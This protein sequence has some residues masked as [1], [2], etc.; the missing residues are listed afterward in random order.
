M[1][2]TTNTEN[3]RRINAKGGTLDIVDEY[4]YLKLNKENQTVEIARRTRWP[5]TVKIYP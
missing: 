2:K 5:W 3:N 4:I 1:Q